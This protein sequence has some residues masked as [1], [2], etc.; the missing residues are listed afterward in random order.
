MIDDTNKAVP[1][2]AEI[3][4]LSM[5]EIDA[6]SGAGLISWLKRIFG[7]DGDRRR[8][9]DRTGTPGVPPT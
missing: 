1:A 9:T 7:G 3:R 5:D 6:T 2:T 8:P 4:D